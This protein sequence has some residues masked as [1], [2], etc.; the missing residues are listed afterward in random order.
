MTVIVPVTTS[1]HLIN[2]NFCPRARHR[3]SELLYCGRCFTVNSCIAH[4]YSCARVF[5]GTEMTWTPSSPGSY[6]PIT[7]KGKFLSIKQWQTSENQ[8]PLWLIPLLAVCQLKF[9]TSNLQRGLVLCNTLQWLVMGFFERVSYSFHHS[10]HSLLYYNH[11]YIVDNCGWKFRS[12]ANQV[13]SI[14]KLDICQ[15]ITNPTC[16]R[17]KQNCK[18]PRIDWVRFMEQPVFFFYLSF[19]G[20]PTFRIGYRSVLW[21]AARYCGTSWSH[22]LYSE[23]VPDC[24]VTLKQPFDLT[25]PCIPQQLFI[26]PYNLDLGKFWPRLSVHYKT[27]LWSRILHLLHISHSKLEFHPVGK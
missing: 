10:R 3:C 6:P 27:P 21:F 22:P 23:L 26:E 18:I 2:P 7:W 5:D 9:H 15:K 8:S 19:R 11:V 13:Q 25:I 17:P 24:A 1:V 20:E 16:E 14:W 4:M 12:I